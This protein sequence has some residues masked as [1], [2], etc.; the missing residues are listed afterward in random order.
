MGEPRISFIVFGYSRN[1]FIYRS[2]SVFPAVTDNKSNIAKYTVYTVGIIKVFIEIG[3]SKAKHINSICYKFRNCRALKYKY[4][5]YRTS[6]D[7][8]KK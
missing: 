7:K 4:V 5:I 3:D 6:G 1:A 8:S 2:Y